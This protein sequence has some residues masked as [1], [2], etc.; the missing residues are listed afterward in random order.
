MLF[1]S[2]DNKFHTDLYYF[3]VLPLSSSQRHIRSDV[4]EYNVHGG[5][6]KFIQHFNWK[7]LSEGTILRTYAK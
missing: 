6:E 7:I 2:Q 1:S 4:Q 5:D 3:P